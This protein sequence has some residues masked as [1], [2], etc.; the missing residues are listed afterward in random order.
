MSNI[1]MLIGSLIPIVSNQP[2]TAGYA[3]PQVPVPT[4][5]QGQAWGG[6]QVENPYYAQQVI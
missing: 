2:P 3:P 6:Q 5:G 4:Q 1:T